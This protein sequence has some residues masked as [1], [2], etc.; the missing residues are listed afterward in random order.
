MLKHIKYKN[1]TLNL[2]KYFCTFLFS[3]LFLYVAGNNNVSFNSTFYKFNIP[4]S[5]CS[6]IKNNGNNILYVA[7]N[8]GLLTY[9]GNKWELI[10]HASPCYSIIPFKD[11]IYYLSDSYIGIIK[12]QNSKMRAYSIPLIHFIYSKSLFYIRCNKEA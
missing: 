1:N 8:K 9:N 2:L 10:S 11:S 3:T 5:I 12:V 6:E 4:F 7:S